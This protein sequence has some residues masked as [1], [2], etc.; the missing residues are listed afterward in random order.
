MQC[1]LMAQTH[2]HS[3]QT[4]VVSVLGSGEHVR[5]KPCCCGAELQH[6]CPHDPS[7]LP[8][9]LSQTGPKCGL[10]GRQ[11]LQHFPVTFPETSHLPR[12]NYLAQL[13]QWQKQAVQRCAPGLGR[14]SPPTH[15][16][17]AGGCPAHLCCENELVNDVS[18]VLT[19]IRKTHDLRNSFRANPIICGEKEGGQN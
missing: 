3:I 7:V 11:T 15:S 14:Q 10:R 8:P 6:K 16:A 17:D 18:C 13:L 5:T 12:R 2:P 4:A 1:K 9:S 19:P